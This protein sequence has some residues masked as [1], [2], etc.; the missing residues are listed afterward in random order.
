MGWFLTLAF[1]ICL[2]MEWKPLCYQILTRLSIQGVTLKIGWELQFSHKL[3]VSFYL[4]QNKNPELARLFDTERCSFSRLFRSLR[5]LSRPHGSFKKLW[6]EFVEKPAHAG[7]INPSLRKKIIWR[8]PA[9]WHREVQLFE[10]FLEPTQ[11]VTASWFIKKV[12]NGV[13]RK[14]CLRRK[15]NKFRAC[16]AFWHREVRLCEIIVASWW[17]PWCWVGASLPFLDSLMRYYSLNGCAVLNNTRNFKK[18]C[19]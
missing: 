5:N 6:T 7:K 14:A 2:S 13:R 12:A 4:I 3:F 1:R 16:E 17:C 9:F 15:I 10:I 11:S 19:N 8:K 18:K